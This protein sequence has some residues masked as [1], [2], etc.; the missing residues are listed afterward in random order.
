MLNHATDGGGIA[1]L[2]G[3]VSLRFTLVAFSPGQLHRGHHPRL[4]EL[5]RGH[6]R[7]DGTCR[8][9]ACRPGPG[10]RPVTCAIPGKG[11]GPVD[12]MRSATHAWPY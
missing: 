10:F 3:T 7:P 11:L 12:R 9:R 8:A 1:N 2:T 4:P 6:G 5:A